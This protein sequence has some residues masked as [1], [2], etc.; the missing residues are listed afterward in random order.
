MNDLTVCS[1]VYN[2]AQVG[3]L[4]LMVSSVLK[5]TT[6]I[7]KFLLLDNGGNNLDCY[8]SNPNFIVIDNT[9][10]LYRGSL[11]HGIGLNRLLALST[12]RYTAI[13]ESDCVM[14][15]DTWC[16]LGSS[17]IKAASKGP[18]LYHAC[19]LVFETELLRELDFRPGH[20]DNRYN[21]SY[22]A[23]EDV[24]WCIQERIK[25]QDLLALDLIDCKSGKGKV[26]GGGFQSDEIQC[27][28]K[29]IALHLGR[30]SNL[31]GKKLIPGFEHP[32]VQLKQWKE[33]V[34]NIL[35]TKSKE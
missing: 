20:D 8:R 32:T 16:D 21:R 34:S 3:L 14:V 31:A 28:G 35:Q 12:T 23:S 24:G 17:K 18:G 15:E 9:D 30:G 29:T 7:P 10:S 1:V 33:A 5:H 6:T 4:D 27:D 22:S 2:D 13:I 11:A 19:F 25:P 26:F